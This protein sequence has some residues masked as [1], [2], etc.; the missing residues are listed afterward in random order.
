MIIFVVMLYS[1]KLVVVGGGSGGCSTA[2][3]F[4]SVLPAGNV[5]VIEPRDVSI[6]PI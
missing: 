3:K 1:Y 4:S 6:L 2:A 5:A